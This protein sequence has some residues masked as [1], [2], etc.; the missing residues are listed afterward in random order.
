MYFQWH[1][2][3]SREYF[4]TWTKYI[5][6][7]EHIYFR[8]NQVILAKNKLKELHSVALKQLWIFLW[9]LYCRNRA[10]TKWLPPCRLK[11]GGL[12]ETESWEGTEKPKKK[13]TK[14]KA[15]NLPKMKRFLQ[16]YQT[17]HRSDTMH[18]NALLR[19]YTWFLYESF[20]VI[21]QIFCEWW[22]ES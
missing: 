14:V 8:K 22:W 3:H 19:A 18:H 13:K 17:S 5:Y 2:I 6:I 20:N 11:R 12:G 21:I 16:T 4:I 15:Q 10:Y 7:N 9:E 1:I